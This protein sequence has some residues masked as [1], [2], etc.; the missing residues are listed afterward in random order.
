MRVLVDGRVIQDRY[1]GIGRQAFELVRALASMAGPG[2]PLDLVVLKGSGRD[3]RLS[4]RDLAAI[5]AVTVED[6]DAPV[7]SAKEQ[8]RWP[9]VIRRTRPDVVLAPYHLA[10]PLRTSAP[11]VSVIHD[12][13]FESD[14][15]FAP[16][17]SMRIAYIAAT[18]IALRRAS[19]IVTVSRATREAVQRRYRVRIAP[20][21]VVPNGVDAASA[22]AD[23]S[24]AVGAAREDLGL[25]DRYLLHVGVRRPHKNQETLVRAFARLAPAEPDLHLVL[26]GK[27]DERFPDPVPEL[28]RRLGLG[29]RVRMIASV[30]E[31]LLPGVFAGASVFAFPSFVEGFGIPVLEAM[32]VGTPVV[33]SGTPAVAEVAGDAALLVEPTDVEGFAEAIGRTLRDGGLRARLRER[34]RERVE[35]FRWEASADAL[36]GVLR[37]AAR[38]R[39]VAAPERAVPSG[40]PRG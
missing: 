5:A 1:D 22:F 4:V 7:A 6:F 17:R 26:V 27:R 8:L 15:R 9:G 28:V 2:T 34:G 19:E 36:A 39:G 18:W 29:A 14:P 32:A 11:V 10:A 12:C 23:G 37:R 21:N 38:A 3:D 20:T 24:A 13:I 16:G 30:P 35:R 25:P 33:A 40:P 31:P